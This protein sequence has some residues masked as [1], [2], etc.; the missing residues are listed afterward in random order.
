MCI[1]FIRLIF[2]FWIAWTNFPAII[3]NSL[4]CFSSSFVFW[5]FSTCPPSRTHTH[6]DN[7]YSFAQPQMFY[8]TFFRIASTRLINIYN[9]NPYFW[10]AKFPFFTLDLP[11]ILLTTSSLAQSVQK[12]SSTRTKIFCKSRFFLQINIFSHW[13]WV[14]WRRAFKTNTS[15]KVFCT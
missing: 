1:I 8:R 13:R 5:T 4:L 2:D 3:L 12:V 9:W 15:R 7:F 10:R 11:N 6:T 14:R